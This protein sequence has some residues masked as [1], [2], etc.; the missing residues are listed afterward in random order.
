[1]WWGSK[2][3]AG[4]FIWANIS[5]TW[6]DQGGGE[7]RE[8]KG[9]VLARRGDSPWVRLFDAANGKAPHE[10]AAFKASPPPWVAPR[11]AV[12]TGFNLPLS[13]L[14]ADEPSELSDQRHD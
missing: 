7:G 8:R 9:V 4:S 3:F 10:E 13:S 1:M 5:G 14:L 12:M 6:A 11:E 2:P